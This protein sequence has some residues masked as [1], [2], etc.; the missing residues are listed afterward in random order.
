[1]IDIAVGT[2]RGTKTWKNK[3]VTWEYLQE[4]LLTKHETAETYAEYMA[5]DKARQSEIKD[6][7]AF[8]GGFLQNGKRSPSTI[9]H[10]QVL[11][12][13]A[14][15]AH[16]RFWQTFTMFYSFEALVH[17]THKHN[18]DKPRLR[19][20]IPL[21][22]T[23]SPEEYQ[24]VGRMLAS[25]LG[26]DY[27]DSTGFQP[28]RLMYWPSTSKGG[29][30]Y[31]KSQNGEFL[32]PDAILN[33]YED[34]KDISS[35]PLCSNEREMAIRGMDKQGDP[36]EKKGAIGAFCRV[37]SITEA[38]E[39]FLPEVY[40]SAGDT[41]FTFNGGST[42]GGAIN[43]NDLYLYS[44]HSTD[45][46]GGH[47][48]NAFDLVRIHKFG[49]LDKD[50]GLNISK[51]PSFIEMMG[52]ASEADG[53]VKEMG[54]FNGIP[55]EDWVGTLD[56]DYKGEYQ[57]TI[58]NIY[59][60]LS[61]D[62][63]LKGLFRY[64]DFEE[65][66]YCMGETPWNFYDKPRYL[67]DKD[68]A[69]LRHYLE[70]IYGIFH[71]NK[72]KD[73]L[74]LCCLNNRFNP[75]KEF[76]DN[77]DWDGIPRLESLF[78]ESFGAPD[79]PYTRAVTKKSLSAA[80]ARIYRPGIKFDYVLTLV[81][82]QGLG[83][84]TIFKELGG[85][86]FSDS[87]A[88]IQGKDAFEQLQGVWIIEMGE[89]SG[90]RKAEVEIIKQFISKQEDRYRVAYGRRVETFLRKCIFFGTTNEWGFLKDSS[91]NRRF[92][93][94]SVNKKYVH[95]AINVAQIW[96]EAKELYLQG[97]HLYLDE[98]IEADAKIVQRSHA[99]ND[100][101]IGLIEQYLNTLLPLNWEK[102]SMFERISF[103]SGE[104]LSDQPE[105]VI[106]REKV[107]VAEIWCEVLKGQYKDMT[108]NNTKFIHGILQNI[109]GWER[110]EAN[111]KYSLYGY[112]RSYVKIISDER[113]N[114]RSEVAEA[115]Q[116]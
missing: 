7:G 34:W 77:L 2:S 56:M 87:L 30:F 83:K 45:P 55:D 12:L 6:V 50:P 72:T 116:A 92:W 95:G 9:K 91:G 44:H 43:Y 71:V 28:E 51:Q 110:A 79:T 111:K 69:G 14:D 97:E 33:L 78:I 29:E 36:R 48:C 64:N 5:A 57:P 70:R 37:Y 59:I 19:L 23:I 31:A 102:L 38:I 73:A 86:W 18:A 101:R 93:P 104:P 46:I 60:I 41:R 8:V 54:V 89:L 84:S 42:G 82:P 16:P 107:C 96:A 99:E 39:T 100:E 61:N 17:S 13:D 80:V 40:S 25:R 88:T 65:R 108:T 20:V 98:V 113:E 67:T 62:K 106:K 52:F 15:F 90:L 74:D 3:K 27:F 10:R 22:R 26:I 24:A 35:W 109:E 68:D 49:H 63:N 114:I 66:E 115:N 21:S 53:V 32:D 76:L 105:G 85:D 4:K 103:L 94:V 112:Q 11:T 1:M 81:G 75:P 58:D 47:L